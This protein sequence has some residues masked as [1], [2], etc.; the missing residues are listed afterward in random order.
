MSRQSREVSVY[1]AM[2]NNLCFCIGIVLICA[3]SGCGTYYRVSVDSLNADPAQTQQRTYCLLPGNDGVGEDDLLFR[4]IARTLTPAFTA[5]GF[6]VV[7]P[8]DASGATR[9]S[10]MEARIE[11][12]EEEP[13]T[14][15]QEETVRRSHPVRVRDGKHKDRIE[16]VTIEE[17]VLKVHTNY[18]ATLLITAMAPK[19]EKRQLWRTS[20]T[21]S[22]PVDSFRT[23]LQ[24]MIPAL[25]LTLGKQSSRERFF[26]VFVSD[27]GDISIDEL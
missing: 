18:R 5:Q 16:Y 13:Q 26:E 21:C 3:L 6:D 12:W 19:D 20:V 17:P 22:G 9:A 25:K 7:L 4:D 8:G 11:Y 15:L 2:K 10:C 27:D 1:Y 24:A 14:T 23:L